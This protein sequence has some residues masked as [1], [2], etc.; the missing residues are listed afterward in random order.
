MGNF[1]RHLAIFSGH[2][3]YNL[4]G[5]AQSALFWQQFCDVIFVEPCFLRTNQGV[6]NADSNL[7]MW[8]ILVLK[9][10][11]FWSVYFE[12]LKSIFPEV[13]EAWIFMFKLI[14]KYEKKSLIF[15]FER[16]QIRVWSFQMENIQCDQMPKL[17]SLWQQWKF[18]Q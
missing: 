14:S 16:S 4:S 2:T 8:K 10:I 15:V 11:R 13:F 12:V 18:A 5:M 1:Y 6:P 3:A 17:F 9:I 7:C